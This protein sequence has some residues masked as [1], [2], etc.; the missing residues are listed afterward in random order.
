MPV[1]ANKKVCVFCGSNAGADS[2]TRQSLKNLAE[3]LVENEDTLVYGGGRLGLMGMLYEEV[4]KRNGKVIGIIP[5]I[6]EDHAIK[7]VGQTE[8]IHVSDM[9]DR[10]KQMIELS[11]CFVV[12]PGGLGTMEEFFQTYSWFQLGIVQKPIILVNIDGYYN[13]LINFLKH[14]AETGFMPKENVDALI[15]GDDLPD[16]F[17]KASEFKYVKANKWRN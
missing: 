6:L 16:L 4:S 10:K 15:I 17:S 13:D 14:S 12:F 5:E 8:L 11:D 2:E 9:S 7:P 1:L 3:Y